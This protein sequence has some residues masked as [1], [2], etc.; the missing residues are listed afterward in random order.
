M[1][2][3]L[4]LLD[5]FFG[6]FVIFSF[7]YVGYFAPVSFVKTIDD[8]TL[9]TLCQCVCVCVCV[10]VCV[11]SWWSHLQWPYQR[12][13]AHHVMT[14][15]RRLVMDYISLRLVR[16][17]FWDTTENAAFFYACIRYAFILVT[18]NSQRRLQVN[19]FSQLSVMIHFQ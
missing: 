3:L 12:R 11:C 5:I 7:Y 8:E 14:S 9:A 2:I 10:S 1:Y 4:I 19:R 13:S 6:H 15:A 16:A 18:I 17:L